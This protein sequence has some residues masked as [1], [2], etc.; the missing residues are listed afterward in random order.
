VIR[1]PALLT[2]GMHGT[3]HCIEE[4]WM[5][6]RSAPLWPISLPQDRCLPA[7]RSL[8]PQRS[9]PLVT[10]FPSPATAAPSQRPP[11]RGQR[12]QPAT[13]RPANSL[14]RPVRLLL[15]CLHR[16]A[17]DDGSFFASGPSRLHA[18]TRSAASSASTPL[19]DFCLPRDRS[20]Q[21]IPP[22]CGSP[23]EP[24]RFPLAPRCRFYF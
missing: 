5:P 19:R 24:A 4:P 7:H 15:P 23:S 17:P 8:S 6:R 21:Q 13:S 11:F 22:P 1:F 10:A 12:S 20:V 2:T 16:F 18:P 9:R 3:E 14:P